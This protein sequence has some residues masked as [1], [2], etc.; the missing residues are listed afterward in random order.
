MITTA[1]CQDTVVI[2]RLLT[3][4]LNRMDGLLDAGTSAVLAGMLPDPRAF[5]DDRVAVLRSLAVVLRALL[6]ATADEAFASSLDRL[7]GACEQFRHVLTQ[8]TVPS[9]P[10][11]DRSAVVNDLRG[12][13][14]G[15]TTA[16]AATAIER[17]IVL[18]PSAERAAYRERIFQNLES[19]LAGN[20]QTFPRT[21]PHG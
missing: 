11:T 10:G 13:V 12:S 16:I 8:L 15:M 6:P 1:P 17:G 2:Q 19:C 14:S 5:I 7:L 20:D 18:P 21:V 4:L 3:E 9:S